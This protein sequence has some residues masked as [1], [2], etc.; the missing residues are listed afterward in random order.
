M[1]FGYIV[2]DDYRK[3]SKNLLDLEKAPTDTSHRIIE[4][5]KDDK[6]VFDARS[7]EGK[8]RAFKH[9]LYSEVTNNI[10][11]GTLNTFNSIKNDNLTE[12]TYRKINLDESTEWINTV[13]FTKNTFVTEFVFNKEDEVKLYLVNRAGKIYILDYLSKDDSK[14]ARIF[15][16]SLPVGQ[17]ALFIKVNDTLYKTNKVYQF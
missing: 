15:N 9:A 8:Y 13:D 16:I 12:T 3:T 7:Y 5:D 10:S 6:V 4:L 2:N 14:T 1:N 11:V 17:Y